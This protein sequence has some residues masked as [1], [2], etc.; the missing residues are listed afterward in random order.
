MR[1][2]GGAGRTRSAESWSAALEITGQ[3]GRKPPRSQEDPQP[4]P[5]ASC[6]TAAPAGGREAARWPS[7]RRVLGGTVKKSCLV[8]ILVVTI[9][10]TLSILVP[11][12]SYTNTR[13]SDRDKDR[14]S[15]GE[16]RWRAVFRQPLA[17]SSPAPRYPQPRQLPSG[18]E[19]KL[20]AAAL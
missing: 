4:Q 3:L 10:L 6:P 17:S 16:T 9:S 2:G 1:G 15:G 14:E 8:L 5:P 18:A 19:G 11:A 20:E 12:F 7:G 13:S